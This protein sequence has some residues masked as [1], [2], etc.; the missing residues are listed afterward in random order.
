M[1]TYHFTSRQALVKLD[2]A[3]YMAGETEGGGGEEKCRFQRN[4]F[5]DSMASIISGV[6]S[7]PAGPSLL[8]L[9]KYNFFF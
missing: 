4:H 9:S 3:V 1:Q 2:I 6:P 8:A 7:E 5:V